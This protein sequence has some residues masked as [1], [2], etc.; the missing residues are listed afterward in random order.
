MGLKVITVADFKW[1]PTGDADFATIK[2]NFKDLEERL[3]EIIKELNAVMEQKE[4]FV[5]TVLVET[6]APVTIIEA[7]DHSN[8]KIV[9]GF[10]M[11]GD[12]LKMDQTIS[13]ENSKGQALVEPKTLKATE[14]S[15]KAQSFEVIA[16]RTIGKFDDVIVVPSSVRKAIVS[17]LVEEI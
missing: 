15:G 13:I 7:G 11:A 6:T 12:N 17:I 2:K 16:W 4:K 5:R 14:K 10:V 8:L 1:I 9:S 3:N